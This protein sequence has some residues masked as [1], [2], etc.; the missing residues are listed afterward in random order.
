VRSV[1]GLIGDVASMYT[2]GAVS[3]FYREEWVTDIIARAR[4]SKEFSV[5]TKE[6]ARWAREQQKL[7]QS[8]SLAA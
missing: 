6:T 4:K 2:Q 8:L 7:Q 5:S 1:V 3:Q